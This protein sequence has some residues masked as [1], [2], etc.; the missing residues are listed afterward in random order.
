MTTTYHTKNVNGIPVG[1]PNVI[2]QRK[3]YYVSYNNYDKDIYGCST[4]AIVIGDMSAFLILNGDHRE[5]L[6]GLDIDAVCAYFHNN[7]HLK[8]KLSDHHEK[9]VFKFIDGEPKMIRYTGE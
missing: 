2:T 6:K 1:V 3:G 9:D 8:N 5:A 7:A 4:T